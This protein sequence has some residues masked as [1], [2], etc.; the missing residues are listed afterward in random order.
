MTR[1]AAGRMGFGNGAGRV[2][3]RERRREQRPKA[4][5]AGPGTTGPIRPV[6]FNRGTLSA[7]LP[8]SLS[9]SGLTRRVGSA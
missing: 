3:H 5:A 9:V 8:G 6:G 2:R 1:L 4:R 7:R